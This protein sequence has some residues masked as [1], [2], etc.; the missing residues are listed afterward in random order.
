MDV[1]VVVNLRARK[2]SSTIARRI[3]ER[4]PRARVAVTASLDD[5]RRF[6]DRELVKAPPE[7][8]LSGGGDGTAVTV[9]NELRDRDVR[10]AQLG[11]LRMGTGNGWANATGAPR[12]SRAIAHVAALDEHPASRM[13]SRRFALVEC[14]DRIAPFLGTGWDAEI[15]TDFRAHVA[16]MPP[17]LR[18][19]NQGVAGYLLGMFTRT[20]PRHV[21][22]DG[23]AN[24]TLTNLGEPALT[25]DAVG[26]VVPLPGGERGAVLYHG[27]A[28]VAA[29]GTTEEWGFGFRAFPFAHTVPGR[30]NARVYGGPVLEA[31][32]QMFRLWRGEHPVP[33]MH[34]FF[35]THGRM[36]FD[37]EVPFQVGGDV[38]GARR[39]FEF[40]IASEAVD[41]VDWSRVAAA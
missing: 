15:I 17:G 35:L 2:A 14:D 39:S 16:R 20:I 6:I 8:L 26:R 34:D 23:P 9:L 24:V 32:R 33:R 13:P 30:V 5:L 3:A 28:S 11:V 10:I 38:G 41:L 36:D 27:P 12:A 21:L 31:T 18:P 37:R 19:M 29:A 7:L 1:A 40:R 4:L 25:V 22:G